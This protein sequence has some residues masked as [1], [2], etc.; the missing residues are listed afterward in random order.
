M[1]LDE[2]DSYGI[3]AFMIQGRIKGKN[4]TVG[5]FSN[6]P[7]ELVSLE[8]KLLNCSSVRVGIKRKCRLP[9]Q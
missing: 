3:K 5:Y 7:A 8:A 2:G 6:A 4:Q 1:T 9:S